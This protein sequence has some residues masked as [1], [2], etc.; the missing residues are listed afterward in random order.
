MEKKGQADRTRRTASSAD[1]EVQRA[2]VDEVGFLRYYE[3]AMKAASMTGPVPAAADR[4]MPSVNETPESVS[5]N[6]IF[7]DNPLARMTIA[8]KDQL[9]QEDQMDKFAA[10]FSR[11]LAL[12]EL[13]GKGSLKKWAISRSRNPQHLLYPDAVI[14]AAAVSPLKDDFGFEVDEF[15]RVV[16]ERMGYGRPD[17]RV[18]GA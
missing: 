14:F 3:I 9:T 5:V 12:I 2:P 1:E 18:A 7:G 16:K 8:I 6:V 15:E 4:V 17:K 10:V 13:I 11:I